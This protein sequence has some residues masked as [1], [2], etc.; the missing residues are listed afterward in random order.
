MVEVV[1]AIIYSDGKFLICRRPESKSRALKWEFVGGKV[2]QGETRREAL[3]RECEEELS[4]TV[5]PQE[6][7]A[8][9][10]YTYPDITIH[11]TF[12]SVI[13]IGGNITLNEHVDCRWI[14][15]DEAD[16]YEFC[17]ADYE[18][19]KKLKACGGAISGVVSRG[20]DEEISDTCRLI[21]DSGFIGADEAYARVSDSVFS[22]DAPCS[23]R[24]IAVLTE[25]VNRLEELSE[26]A[27]E[28]KLKYGSMLDYASLK[29]SGAD[30]K[31]VTEL[32]DDNALHLKYAKEV[33]KDN[34]AKRDYMFGYPANMQKDSFFTEYL[35]RLEGKM[36]FM[37]N[38][39]DPFEAGNYSMDS[40]RSE[41]EILKMFAENFSLKDGEYWGYVTSG[42]TEGNFW[43][44]REG[45]YR[46][47]DARLYFSDGAH[48]SVDKF[49]SLLSVGGKGRI[50]TVKSTIGGRIDTDDFISKVLADRKKRGYKPVIV[51]LTYG[52]TKEGAIDDI[53]AVT[54]WL[55]K[56][57]IEYYCHV[58]AAFY[59]GMGHN[60]ISAPVL[61][62]FKKL[63]ADSVSVSLHK[64]IGLPCVGGVVISLRREKKKVVDYI[65]QEDSTLSGSRSIPPFSA[66][67]RVKEILT[68]TPPDA[69]VKNV[70]Y[71]R[72]ALES[73]KVAYVTSATNTNIFVVD[74]PSD[75]IV[76]KYQ[77]A[78]FTASGEKK[79]HII[80]MPFHKKEVMDELATDLQKDFAKSKN[81]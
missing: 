13:I 26:K 75:F 65:G 79:A 32:Y 31:T 33:F 6:V 60:Q 11:L 36:Y 49:A 67:Q 54:G 1:A 43:G 12:Y 71:F 34:I 37:N 53:T 51:L 68:L 64:Y 18:V 61:G 63:G 25:A 46:Y 40:K 73:R 44:M 5:L 28:L 81:S 58:D 74:M 59:G 42:G 24:D 9:V 41:R 2:E 19:L 56:N 10:T 47:P 7:F 45:F 76:K 55:K 22:S 17:P 3:V 4:V 15:A 48:Y 66:C 39:G 57:N 70:G 8:D 77:L 23:D 16:M 30:K 29:C 78:T 72:S 50:T 62:D 14:T 21:G 20:S 80:I 38:C 69:Y 52:T 27:A 35:R